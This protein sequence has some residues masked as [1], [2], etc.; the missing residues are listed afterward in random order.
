VPPRWLNQGGRSKGLVRRT[1][2][3]RFPRLGFGRQKKV[4][5]TDF[6][7]SIIMREGPAALKQ[8]ESASHLAA[9]GLL[10]AAGLRAASD[11]ALAEGRAGRSASLLSNVLILEAW[12]RAHA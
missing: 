7:N 9:L 8:V 1:L 3:E 10:D 4:V 2:A 5:A 6:F 11:H 12:L